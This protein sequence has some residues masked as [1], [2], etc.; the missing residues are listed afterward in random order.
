MSVRTIR[1]A[2]S[3]HHYIFR[4]SPGMEDSTI[5]QIMKLADSR[6]CDIDWLDAATLSF[7]IARHM[8]A[9]WHKNT[10]PAPKPQY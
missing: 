6:E 4:Y 5:D 1:F 3:G 7:Q 8:A 2:K 9:G 10:E